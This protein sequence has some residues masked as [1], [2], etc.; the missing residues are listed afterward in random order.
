MDIKYEDHIYMAWILCCTFHLR[1]EEIDNP[2]KD[3]LISVFN[4]AELKGL[5]GNVLPKF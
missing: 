5:C 2:N 4:P 1:Q 3:I